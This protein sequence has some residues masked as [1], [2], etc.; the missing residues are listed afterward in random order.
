VIIDEKC[1][2]SPKLAVNR[3]VEDQEPLLSRE[4]LQSN[5]LIDMIQE[6]HSS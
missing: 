3:P 4:E 1:R 2:V 6:N 5:M